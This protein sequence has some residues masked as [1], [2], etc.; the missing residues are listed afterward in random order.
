MTEP[1]AT[2]ALAAEFRAQPD[3]ARELVETVL[4]LTVG[5]LVEVACEREVDGKADVF[6]RFR[7]CRVS[8]EAKFDHAITPEQLDK[9]AEHCDHLILLV[10][11]KDDASEVADRPGMR[12]I[13]WEDLLAQ[14]P[15]SRLTLPDV[16][17]VDD[18]KRVARRALRAVDV[19][20][21]LSGPGWT[22]RRSETGRGLP[23]IYLEAPLARGRNVM[24]QIAP[25]L[26]FTGQF[27]VNVG[28]AVYPRD[29]LDAKKAAEEPEWVT[30]VR[31][32]CGQLEPLLTA[33][34]LAVSTT[35]GRGLTGRAAVKVAQVGHW[36][37]PAH[38]AVGY[39]DSYLG[40]KLLPVEADGLQSVVDTL[41]PR[42]DEAR[43]SVRASFGD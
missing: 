12:V 23:D 29:F 37:L 19:E 30:L 26:K 16:L 28:V 35:G 11:D 20:G 8:I 6:L 33:A 38:H 24:I 9:L 5:A 39:T 22:W 13:T 32:F 41:V 31:A 2:R 34:G 7:E 36:K 4:G 3:R 27:I 43:L 21:A 40:L 15:D 10:V 1:L 42:V 14:L 25:D 17:A 18:H